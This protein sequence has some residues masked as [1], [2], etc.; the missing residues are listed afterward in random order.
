[1]P[2]W[3]ALTTAANGYV[4]AITTSCTVSA[5]FDPK[6]TRPEDYPHYEE[7]LTAIWD[8]GATSCVISQQVVDACGLKPIGMA[9]VQ[10]VHGTADA[11]TYLVNI[12]LPNDVGFVNFQATKGELGNA[13]LLIGMDVIRHGDFIITNKDAKTVFSFRT[14]SQECVDY[15]KEHQRITQREQFTH[16][17]SHKD[18]KKRHKTFGKNKRKK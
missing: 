5:G 13:H 9:K 11:E 10:G 3:Q 7:H 18:R 15:V 8:T 4:D 2:N 17:G 12:L 1:M 16:G 14:P 6:T